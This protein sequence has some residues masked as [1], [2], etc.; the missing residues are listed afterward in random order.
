M[1]H[2]LWFMGTIPDAFRDRMPDNAVFALPT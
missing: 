1:T 2:R